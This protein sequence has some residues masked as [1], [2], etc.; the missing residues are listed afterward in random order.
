MNGKIL[1]DT[2]ILVELLEG[3]SRIAS[4]ITDIEICISGITEIELLSNPALSKSD[5]TIIEELLKLCIKF[6]VLLPEIK[7]EASKYR[8]KKIIKKTPDAII[9]G[10]AKYYSI[11][12]LTMDKDFKSLSDVDVIIID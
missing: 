1:V 9:A 8:R 5:V 7:L 3:N 6:D 12:L 10:T 11:P 2:N 4:Y